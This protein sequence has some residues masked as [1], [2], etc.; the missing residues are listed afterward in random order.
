[1]LYSSGSADTGATVASAPLDC[2][3]DSAFGFECTDK[4][5]KRIAEVET[6]GAEGL[7]RY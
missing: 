1:V 3:F 4:Q 6:T 7:T 5:L 2:A